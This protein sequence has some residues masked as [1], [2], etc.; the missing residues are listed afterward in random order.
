V[1]SLKAA[2]PRPS[3]KFSWLSVFL[4]LFTA[5]G[6]FVPLEVAFNRIWRIERNRTF[7]RNQIISLGLIFGCGMLVLA[8][9]SIT[10]VNA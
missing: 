1:S 8:N 2:F 10:T 5:N 6:I 3:Q 9:V 4:L 7:L